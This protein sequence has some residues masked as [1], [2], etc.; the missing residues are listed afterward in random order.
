MVSKTSTEAEVW[1]TALLV[2]S[3][4]KGLGLVEK[5]KGTEAFIASRTGSDGA[6][7]VRMST[8]FSKTVDLIYSSN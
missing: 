4:D 1:S 2:L 3:V 6:L 5:V 7:V 8:G